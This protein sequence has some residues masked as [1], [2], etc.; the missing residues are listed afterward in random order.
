[1][2]ETGLFHAPPTRAVGRSL[3][4]A[5][6]WSIGLVFLDALALGVIAAVV[7]AA[8]TVSTQAGDFLSVL[9]V[10]AWVVWIASAIVLIWA[11]AYASTGWGSR[12][13]SLLGVI[14]GL[15]LGAGYTLLGAELGV[16]VGLAAGWAVVIPSEKVERVLFRVVPALLVGIISIPGLSFLAWVGILAVSPWIAAL[17]V[18]IGDLVWT[19]LGRM[20]GDEE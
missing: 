12:V 16:V 4:V 10:A 11:G 3:L 13:R 6:L 9:V 8:N 20:R 17:L 19:T 15:A 14:V 5:C 7:V 18:L 2:Q 1:V